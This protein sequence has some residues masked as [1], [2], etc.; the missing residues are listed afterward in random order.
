M[1]DLAQRY[2]TEIEAFFNGSLDIVCDHKDK[3]VVWIARH[4]SEY[5]GL[6]SEEFDTLTIE[7]PEGGQYELAVRMKYYLPGASR[8]RYRGYVA[9]PQG[10]LRGVN[11]GGH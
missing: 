8:C 11:T 1:S 4:R 10:F 2:A 3:G 7:P 5:G 6:D 9:D